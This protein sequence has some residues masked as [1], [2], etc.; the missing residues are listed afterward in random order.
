[1]KKDLTINDKFKGKTFVIFDI[2]TTQSD[3]LK[4]M[5]LNR[6][7]VQICIIGILPKMRVLF[8]YLFPGFENILFSTSYVQS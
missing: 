8:Y 5:R 6:L 4:S 2:N 1:M 7:R 3:K